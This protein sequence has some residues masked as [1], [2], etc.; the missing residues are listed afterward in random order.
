MFQKA[1]GW[2]TDF[3]IYDIYSGVI[4]LDQVEVVGKRFWSRNSG[5]FAIHGTAVMGP[6]L[7]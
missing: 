2:W 7:L 3:V 4:S 1:T 6:R 5:R